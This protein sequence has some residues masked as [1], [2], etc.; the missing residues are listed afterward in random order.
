MNEVV[1]D[2]NFVGDAYAAAS[3][4][5]DCQR[6][7]NWYPEV[8][9]AKFAGSP[10]TGIVGQRGVVAL[11]PTPGLLLRFTLAA[12]GEVRAMHVVPGGATLY[13]VCGNKLYSVTTGYAATERG[14]LSSSTGIVKITDNGVALY[15]TDG[16]NRYSYVIA[17]TTFATVSDGAFNGGDVCDVID[18]YM[19]YNNPA[20]NQWGW[21]DVGAITSN[22]LNVG[23]KLTGPDYIVAVVAD[24]RQILLLG[25]KT[26]E[27]WTDVGGGVGK[28]FAVI[29]G[30]SIQHGCQAKFSVSRLG[31]G[32]AFLALDTRGQA[33]VIIWG[34][35][36]ATPQRISNFA[37][38]NAIQGYTTTSDAVGYTYAQSGHE[39]YML[40]FPTE[41]VTWC[42][43]LSTQKWHQRAYRDTNGM[44]LRHRSNCCA[45]FNNEILVGDYS[46][47]KVY[48]LS[49]TTYTDD[50]ATIP[51][52]RTGP[53]IT[54]DLKRQFFSY[55]QIQFQPGVGIA[56]GQGSDPE[57]ILR[58]S[59]DGGF[60]YGNDHTI[61][62]GQAGQYKNRAI[63]RRL[64][65]ARDRVF[66]IEVTDP[67]YRVVVSANL[68]YKVGNN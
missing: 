46:N 54:S 21:T 48:A 61:K 51:C 49:Q 55:L 47:G 7:I 11:Y 41:N 59:D 60:T 14:T 65:F 32:V 13:A 24:H 27:R 34:A 1:G 64:G 38:E 26:S 62:I 3:V 30:S 4:T 40:T 28:E 33:T 58:W 63:K 44:L 5:Q 16:S 23:S 53:H 9:A 19:I 6:L 39:F 8:D 31:E 57:C 10:S 42:Y 37:I 25:E 15:I 45:V 20:A 18:N 66:E 68:N 36:V 35:S 67:V 50:G 56:T 17:T 12:L 22:A 52:I 43:D 2:F 29:P